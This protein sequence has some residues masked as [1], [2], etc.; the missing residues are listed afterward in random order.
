M[1]TCID[2]W[3]YNSIYFIEKHFHSCVIFGFNEANVTS[4]FSETIL[5]NNNK[6]E[7]TKNIA[8]NNIDTLSQMIPV[9]QNFLTN[10]MT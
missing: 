6:N 5:I 8:D 4:S 9:V 7:D 2:I 1:L 3:F 10:G